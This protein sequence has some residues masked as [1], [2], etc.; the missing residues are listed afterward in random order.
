LCAQRCDAYQSKG[1]RQK[2]RFVLHNHGFNAIKIVYS[3]Q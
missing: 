3:I 2:G 1:Q